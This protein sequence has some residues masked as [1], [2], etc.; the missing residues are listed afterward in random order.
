MSTHKY[1]GRLEQRENVVES[2]DNEVF[3]KIQVYFII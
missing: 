2:I 1:E 3:Y